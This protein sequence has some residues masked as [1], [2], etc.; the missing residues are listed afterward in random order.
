MG[1]GAQSPAPGTT[2]RMTSA[3]PPR[4]VPGGDTYRVLV[5]LTAPWGDREL[6]PITRSQAASSPPVTETGGHSLPCGRL[7]QLPR[8]SHL[9]PQ[10]TVCSRSTGSHPSLFHQAVSSWIPI[11]VEKQQEQN[12]RRQTSVI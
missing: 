6:G 3:Q 4:G 12:Q 8:N 10:G 7:L 9:L 5:T 2:W 1:K 11:S